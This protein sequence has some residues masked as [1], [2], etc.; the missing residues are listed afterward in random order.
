M[1]LSSDGNQGYLDIRNAILRVG[2]LDVYGITGVDQVTNVVKQN[3][4]LIWDDQGSDMTTPPFQKGAGVA[5]STSPPEI[6]LV[7]SEGNNFMYQGLKLPNSWQGEFDLY[8]ADA[9][10]GAINCHFY[11]TSTTSYADDGY[12]LAFDRENST[13]TLRYDA[14]QVA[15][16]TGVTLSTQWHTASVTFNRGAWAVSLD[17]ERLLTHDD[18][19]RSAVYDNTTGQYVRFETAATTDR[20]VR[21]IKFLNNGAPWLE[22]NAG[23]LY[24]LSS[25]VAIGVSEDDYRFSVAGTAN[26]GATTVTSIAVGDDTD[27]TST[28]TGALTVQGLGVASN[29]HATNVYAT[30]V[31]VGTHAGVDAYDFSVHGTANTGVLTATSIVVGDETEAT[32]VS[33]G[34]LQTFALGV[35]SNIHTNNLYSDHANTQ[36]LEVNETVTVN[37]NV[38]AKGL[39]LAQV[40][41]NLVTWDST[42][43]D[44]M[45]SGGLISNK[46]AIVSEQ[47]PAALTGAS[48]VVEG[49]GRYKVTASSEGGINT[50]P[51]WQTFNKTNATTGGSYSSSESY[52]TTSP[53]AHTGGMSLGGV[54]GEWVK[55]EL[56]YKTKLRHIS[57]QVRADNVGKNMPGAF[58]II[59]SN[60]N[61]SWTTLGSFSGLTL[62]DYTDGVQKQFVVNATE[63][64]KYYA[65]VV[66]NIAGDA[67]AGRLILGEW[68]LF[69]ETFTVDAGVVSTTAASGLDVGYT[70]HPV[71]PMTDYHTYVEGHGTY[72]VSASTYDSDNSLYPWYAFDYVTTPPK[73]WSTPLA[74]YNTSGIYTANVTSTDIGGTRHLGEWLQIKLPYD[75]TLSKIKLLTNPGL[76]FRAVTGG[77]IL[78]SNDGTNW[79]EITTFSDLSHTEGEYATVDINATTP[80]MYYRL[81]VKNVP[82]GIANNRPDILEWRLFAEKPVTR[83]ENVHISGDLSS[84]TLQTGYIKW[85]KVPLKANE[86]GGYVVDASSADSG[87]TMIWSAFN[88][89]FIGQSTEYWDSAT[90]YSTSTGAHD[91]TVS[92]TDSDGVTR[93]GEWIQIKLTNAISLHSMKWYP[94]IFYSSGS[95]YETWPLERVPK[96]GVI[97][98]SNDGITWHTLRDFADISYTTA[99]YV[100]GTEVKVI[101]STPYVYYRLVIT[102]LN[103]GTGSNRAGIMELQLFEAATGV[104]ATPTSA[105]L[106]VAGSLGMA[107][108]SEF[109]AGDDVVME[110]PKHDRPLVKYPEVAM[111]A[112]S[113]GGYVAS[114]S[115]Y[116]AVSNYPPYEAFNGVYGTDLDMWVSGAYKYLSDGTA[117]TSNCATFNGVYGEYLALSMPNKIKLEKI[118]VHSRNN[119]AAS[120]SPENGR[121]Y[122]SNDNSTW[123]QIGTYT[124][125]NMLHNDYRTIIV[126]ASEY[127]KDY[128]FQIEKMKQ[129]GISTYTSIAELEYWGYEEGDT[130]VD[131]VHRSI[132]NTPGQQHLE[133]YWDANDSNSYSFADSSSVYDLSGNGRMGTITGNNGFDAEYNAW[134]FDGSGD[135]ISGTQGLGTGQ[136]VHSQ[137]I[138]FKRNGVTGTYQY[139]NIIGTSGGGT[140]AGF[141]IMNN[142]VTLQTSSYGNDIRTIDTVEGQWYHAVLVHT[143]GDW[144]SSNTLT[145]VNGELATVTS[146][147]KNSTFNLTGTTVRLGTNTNG[148]EG[149]NGS[150][151][152]FRLF[153]KALNADQVRELYEYDAP[154]F[155]HRQN[156]VALHKGN[157]GVGVAHPTSRFE[158]AGA[159]GL[160]EYPPRGITLPGSS[161][162]GYRLEEYIEGYGLFVV[163]GTS[164]YVGGGTD[165]RRSWNMFEKLDA[166]FHTNGSYATT[167]TPA[168]IDE[169]TTTANNDENFNFNTRLSSGGTIFADWV[170]LELPYKILLKQNSIKN[171]NILS[172]SAAKGYIVASNDGLTFDVL[173]TIG[174]FG[175][176]TTYQEKTFITNTNT[177]YRIYRLLFTHKVGGDSSS[178]LNMGEWR[179]FG[180]PAPSSLEDGHLTLGKALT[181]PRVSGHPTGAETPR[182]E[183]LVVHYDTTVDSVV[184]G[185]TVV[186]ISGEENNGTLASGHSYSSTE[187]SFVCSGSSTAITAS[188]NISGDATVSVSMWINIDTLVI[189]VLPF[190]A[191]TINQNNQMIWF[192]ISDGVWKITTGGA[193][194]VREYSS[195]PVVSNTWQ[196]VVGTWSTGTSPSNMQL[197]IDGVQGVP[198]ASSGSTAKT[199][200]SNT[201]FNLGWYLSST[202]KFDGSISN[203]KIWDVALTA[204]EVAME[205]ALGRTGK[206]LNLTDTSLCLGGT[207][208]R[209]QLDVRGTVWGS[210]ARFGGDKVNSAYH[211]TTDSTVSISTTDSSV[212]PLSVHRGTSSNDVPAISIAVNTLSATV[213]EYWRAIDFN[214]LDFRQCGINLI[215]Y[216]NTGTG[217]YNLTAR[218]KTGIG[219]SVSASDGTNVLENAMVVRHGGNVG[220]GVTTPSVPLHIKQQGDSY[221]SAAGNGNGGIRFERDGNANRWDIYQYSNGNLH[222]DYNNSGRAYVWSGTSSYVK[223]NFTGQHRT[224]IKDTP[225]TRAEELEGLIVSADNNKYIK[226]SGG[227][228]AGSNAITTNESLPLVSL[229]TKV[230]DKKC[231]GVISASEEP[232]TREDAYGSFV[233]PYEKEL[234]DTRVYINSVGEGA[235]WVVNTAGTLESGDYITTSNV[236][237]YGQRQ[238]DDI[239]HNY[240]VAKI[241]MDCDFNPPDIPVQRILKELSNITYWFQLEDATSNAHDRTVEET[242]YTTDRHVEVYGHVDEQSNVFVPPEHDVELYV[243]TQVNTVSEEVWAALPEDERVLYDANTFTYTQ[244]IE[245][246]PEVWDDLGVEEQNTYAH[247]YFNVVTDEVAVDTP[248]A[249]ER[250]RTLYKKVV[251]DTKVEPETP[252]D[253]LSEVREEWVNVL[254]EHG[255]LQWEDVPWGDTEPAYKL[256]YLDAEGQITTRHNAVHIAAFV[257]VTY[258]CG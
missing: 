245:I 242:Y 81:V 21:Y 118:R 83:M 199:L 7:D 157:L 160:Q 152:N 52:T 179:L 138:W 82:T 193:G 90:T 178:I 26:L 92:T 254:D 241:T 19:E 32:S 223:M 128:T 38:Y 202:E 63:H 78:G 80:Y 50:H 22:S 54:T 133:V 122:G 161:Y 148:G 131:V 175:Y 46:L 112:N 235:M 70:E 154:R 142:G 211:G 14:A 107:K 155:G 151:A 188:T 125:L 105:K 177:Y 185:S 124:G 209:A 56:P 126:N 132:P 100:E 44:L 164:S 42:T 174:D 251:N 169:A 116:Y 13:I 248:G 191:G 2:T 171:R 84:E 200:P 114:A 238:D 89:V 62:D 72:E 153:G 222:F 163:D 9:T 192:G 172:R 11:T 91:N 20:K 252:E 36:T 219:F 45:D 93:Y 158:V 49:H 180:T 109:F 258:H 29:L 226:M 123:T 146:V 173:N 170:Q 57:L 159:D 88:D 250:T 55:L 3:S 203:F 103:A 216:N 230:N 255:Q 99:A 205:Y 232:E 184:S 120:Q 143:G 23:H 190:I 119:P 224:F 16:A 51:S 101:S 221:P 24:N 207:V 215:N 167:G 139:I 28:S 220:I 196:H 43:G 66:T 10:A 68:R 187:R 6:N 166:V 156:L 18:D 111:T 97:M 237:G 162:V 15:Q 41:S 60:D 243:K 39:H 8:F 249:V 144:T 233:T 58:S 5:R 195:F 75:I 1:S 137:S 47:P 201:S 74:Q 147:S 69:T 214:T 34:A 168:A 65:I 40:A 183:S 73:R 67:A 141:V 61:T 181:L 231:F 253:Y 85:P 212:L 127:Y 197:Y 206:S 121:I 31:F 134:V 64:Y 79:Y 182:A 48:T 35:E 208:P 149:F 71:E 136:P 165:D 113:S 239:L 95:T 30:N 244:T 106:Q 86:S 210:A 108:G 17:G 115:S 256:R 145:Y 4:V 189:T 186:D 12:E 76:I 217:Q 240:T 236:A 135:Y 102:S 53:Y 257:G 77:T 234:G 117:D 87:F 204:E 225:F 194:L 59:G 229:S 247:G 227:I 246:A 150:I 96:S 130:S 218:R 213:G 94:R 176:T 27:S 140:Q 110:L 25:N 98:G 129:F 33:T 228:E 104:G 37:A 198:S